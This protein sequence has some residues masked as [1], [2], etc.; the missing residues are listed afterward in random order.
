MGIRSPGGAAATPVAALKTP[1]APVAYN[2]QWVATLKIF[3]KFDSKSNKM[4]I[5]SY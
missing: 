5:V 4:V 1:V 2:G 3:Q